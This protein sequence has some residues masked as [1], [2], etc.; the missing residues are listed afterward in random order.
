MKKAVTVL[1]GA[2][3][4]LA[5][6]ALLVALFLCAAKPALAKTGI[7]CWTTIDTPAPGQPSN[8]IVSP[9]EINAIAI[10]SDGRTF[11][12][13]DI[14]NS[15]FYKST[16]GGVSWMAE[17]SSYL[18]DNGADLPVWNIAVAPDDE[19]FIVAVTGTGGPKRVFI[20]ESGGGSWDN[21]SFPPLATGE[22]ISCVD[23][24]MDYGAGNRDI[25]VGTRDGIGNGKVYMAKTRGF[26]TWKSQ[27]SVGDVVALK[28]S[29]DYISDFGLVV[30]SATAASTVLNLGIHQDDNSTIWNK[31][32]SY[33][34]PI[35]TNYI[36][37]SPNASQ[38]ITADLE[39]PSD[40]LATDSKLRRYYV[41]TDAT[42]A[43]VQ[44]G[45]YRIED[46]MV[47]RIS[48]PGGRISTIAYSGTCEGGELLAGEV[49]TDGTEAMVKVWRTS[50]PLANSPTWVKSDGI[51][52]PTGG[53][54]SGFANAQ[55]AWSPGGERAYC[56]TSSAKLALAAHWPGTDPDS[57]P[58][59]GNETGYLFRVPLDESAFSISLDG[60][61][62][63][64]QLSLIDTEISFLSDVAVLEVPESS[65]D[66][67][68]LYLAS[69][70]D[71]ATVPRNFDSIWR[72]TSD[73]WGRTWERILCT[74]TVKNDT[75]LRVK[76]RTYDEEER[77]RIIVFADRL[78]DDVLYSPDEGQSWQVLTP[79]G[80][81]TVT[82]L[83]PASDE[84]LYILD[85]TR[86]RKGS[87]SGAIWTWQAKVETCL[88]SAHTIATPLKNPKKESGE[89]NED[90]VI[91]GDGGS[92]QVAYAD[93]SE[94]TVTF[95][96]SPA[97]PVPGNVHVIADEK[98]EQ[99]KIIY[100]AGHNFPSP[101]TSGKI[102]R[103]AIGKSTNWDELEPPNSAFHG[104]A[105]RNDVLYGAWDNPTPPHASPGVDR[106]LY[107]RATVPPP[108]EWDDLT[109]A[110]TPTG[111]LPIGV[112]FTR[113][114]SSLKISGAD[115]NNLW[116]IDNRNYDWANEV[117]CLWVYTDNM[118]KV[119][120]W[121]TAP[122]SGDLIPCD[123]VSGRASEIN[124][125][126]RELN[127]AWVYELQLAKDDKFSL[128]ILVDESITPAD[129][130]S[131]AYSYPAGGQVP[132]PAS[133]I[134]SPGNLECG[135]GYYWRVRVRE[136]TSGE[137][138]RSPWSVTMYFGVKAG[139][140]AKS[141]HLGP[142]LL[143]PVNCAKGIS[144][145]PAFSWTPLPGTNK[146]EFTLAKDA[147]L[148]QVITK[149]NVSTTAYEYDGELDWNAEYFW[150]VRALEPV[151][152]EPSPVASFKVISS[153][154]LAAP[155][156]PPPSGTPLW[157]WAA[158]AIHT[159]LLV[160]VIVFIRAS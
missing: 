24:S 79:G 90:W 52:S 156:V 102:Y 80:D 83:T 15:K 10:G 39:L 103:W 44:T 4:L 53:G 69:I 104:L 84:V 130:L 36:G 21:A 12:A 113:E 147:S 30:V 126:W 27:G 133:G 75:I 6:G 131:P 29:P 37:N 106:T 40:F 92:G 88:D 127:S 157:I 59:S 66:Y 154:P 31:T 112:S 99:N 134:A 26:A 22:F 117:G 23:I 60:G 63:W 124:F 54:N 138:V 73:P 139:F 17:L 94:S 58:G 1:K 110:E 13:I 132:M 160:A 107:P 16:D 55:I 109:A 11:Y 62:I 74:A 67:S 3:L 100:A 145:P 33:P 125:R 150:Q 146:Y 45:V 141:E 116:A 93:F 28:F 119:G 8:I 136:G 42:V 70:N 14:P 7:L 35:D 140:P 20:S 114:P 105:Q 38:I 143:R 9:S 82:D 32:I 89:D 129:P 76:P 121:T 135:H 142:T 123:P 97:V 41:S 122:A 85:D 95:K 48:P 81:V 46:T 152:S 101:G 77:S 96:L 56:A 51:K 47:Y 128:R 153:E 155:H 18:H 49:K 98:F 50:N 2:A 158:I 65:E 25:A 159:A 64:N 5:Y 68:V 78:T 57:I 144:P 91:V 71:N 34:V 120:P 43:N 151:V 137:I 61:E 108:L 72:T 111:E 118:A 148:T 86:V 115:Y 149:V 19:N 87:L